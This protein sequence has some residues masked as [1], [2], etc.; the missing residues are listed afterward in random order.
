[1]RVQTSEQESAR[2][3]TWLLAPLKPKSEI[4]YTTAIEAELPMRWIP[5]LDFDL[6]QGD[7]FC[8]RCNLVGFLLIECL[9]SEI[10]FHL[11]ALTRERHS[12]FRRAVLVLYLK[13][14]SWLLLVPVPRGTGSLAG[15]PGCRG[16]LRPAV[17]CCLCFVLRDFRIHWSSHFVS[18][19]HLQNGL[20]SN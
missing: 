17:P 15:V 7:D 10:T 1:M 13:S 8:C 6:R 16:G 19:S 4:L 9:Y 5:L 11:R 14:R 3:C 12:T 2:R 18:P 20:R